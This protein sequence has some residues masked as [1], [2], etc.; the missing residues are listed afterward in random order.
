MLAAAGPGLAMPVAFVER[1][2]PRTIV[3]LGDGEA[4]V[5]AVFDNDGA[6]AGIGEQAIVAPAC[7]FGA[8]VRRRLPAV[9]IAAGA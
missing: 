6:G 4:A 8:A 2:G 9:R 3:H 5:K 1:I 7:P